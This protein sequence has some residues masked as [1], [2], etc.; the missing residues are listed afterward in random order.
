MKQLIKKKHNEIR[1]RQRNQGESWVDKYICVLYCYRPK[2]EPD[3]CE[4]GPDHGSTPCYSVS[5]DST[6]GAQAKEDAGSGSPG[7]GPQ[8]QMCAVSTCI[9]RLRM[10]GARIKLVQVSLTLVDRLH[11]VSNLQESKGKL[12]TACDGTLLPDHICTAYT[13]QP[14]ITSTLLVYRHPP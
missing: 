10:H 1:S 7:R 9:A 11:C 12:S 3:R 14:Y 8:L 2:S 13:A 5:S 6:R 4:T